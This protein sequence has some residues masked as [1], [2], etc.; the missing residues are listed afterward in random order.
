MPAGRPKKNPD[1]NEEQENNGNGDNGNGAVKGKAPLYGWNQNEAEITHMVYYTIAN[2][3]P[4]ETTRIVDVLINTLGAHF[5]ALPKHKHILDPLEKERLACEECVI[6]A[7]TNLRSKGLIAASQGIDEHGRQVD[8]YNI[9]NEAYRKMFQEHDVAFMRPLVTTMTMKQ[10]PQISNL[11]KILE[12]LVGGA[13]PAR[14]R[15]KYTIAYIEL[16]ATQVIYGPKGDLPREEAESILNELGEKWDPDPKNAASFFRRGFG[17]Q[18]VF[19]ERAIWKG[20]QE[21]HPSWFG[22]EAEWTVNAWLLPVDIKEFSQEYDQPCYKRP[23]NKYGT[24]I[25]KVPIVRDKKAKGDAN[26][27]LK[28]TECAPP[29]F[30]LKGYIAVADSKDVRVALL[31]LSVGIPLGA[32]RNQGQGLFKLVDYKILGPA[33]SFEVIKQMDL[34]CDEETRQV[35]TRLMEDMKAYEGKSILKGAIDG[36]KAAYVHK[37]G[38]KDG[39]DAAFEATAAAVEDKPLNGDVAA[40]A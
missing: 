10:N 8:L 31:A 26:A 25:A 21:Y 5:R 19:P 33:D 11:I 2:Q 30:L 27:T 39:M 7:L 35:R 40:D 14:E 3:A 17:N 29:G 18:I 12:D 38:I 1:V 28:N 6:K 37:E 36:N 15:V 4:I 13:K 34:S 9:S 32:A 24:Y 16:R 20:L 23:K 22:P